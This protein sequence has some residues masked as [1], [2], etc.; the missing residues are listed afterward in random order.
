MSSFNDPLQPHSLGL[1]LFGNIDHP[2]QSSIT[3]DMHLALR[4]PIELCELVIDTLDDQDTLRACSLTCKALLHASR[5]HLFYNIHLDDPRIS[6]RFLHNICSN[7]SSTSPCQ[8]IRHL[9]LD[10][11]EEA[12][13][14]GRGVWVNNALPILATCLLDVTTLELVFHR[15]NILKDTARIAMLSGF[16]RVKCMAITRN[17]FDSAEQMFQLIASFP[18]LTHLSLPW[19]ACKNDGTT[20]TPLPL[21]LQAIALD[22]RLSFLFHQL[23]S[24]ELHPIVRSIKIIPVRPG[25]TQGVGT[26]LKT[27]GSSLEELDLCSSLGYQ[28]RNAESRSC[29]RFTRHFR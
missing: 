6:Q 3:T 29:C 22:S 5:H 14:Y 23:L 25:Y 12:A 7:L 13:A 4:L 20:C 15:S 10:G 28:Q 1:R 21:G 16:R 9:T 2:S 18:S 27:L 8:H 24:F 11:D 17:I 26:L 19:T